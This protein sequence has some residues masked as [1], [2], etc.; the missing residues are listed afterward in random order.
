VRRF[1]SILALTAIG[2]WGVAAGAAAEPVPPLTATEIYVKMRAAVNR[3]PVP[4]YVAFTEQDAST[5]K[6]TLLQDRLRIVVRV[7][8]AHAWVRTIKNM[9]GDTVQVE[10]NVVTGMV[11]PQTPIERVGEFP[12]ADFG[13]RPRRPG[14]TGMFEAP[15]TPEPTPSPGPL[16]AIGSVTGYNLSYRVVNLGDTDVGGAPVYHLGLFPY[17]DPGHNVL[18][19]VWIDERTF[20]PKR[21]VAERF[22]ENGGLSFRYLITVNTAMVEGHLVN[23]DADGHFEIHRALIIHVAGGGRWAI[24]DVRFP[25]DP[26][27]WLF[28]PDHYKEHAG[29]AVPDL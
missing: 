10:P 20:I 9:N 21:Y 8:D 17:R 4:A 12:L 5:R 6:Y 2:A 14:Q 26:P 22:V 13:L 1:A 19:E 28:D 25:T 18:R 7:S 23:V 29:D 3:L 24:S 15:G 27:G 16:K 11:Y